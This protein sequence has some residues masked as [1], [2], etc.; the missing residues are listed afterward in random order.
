MKPVHSSSSRIT[1]TR[2]TTRRNPYILNKIKMTNLINAKPY[3]M[4]YYG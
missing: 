3:K 4:I 2:M 1:F